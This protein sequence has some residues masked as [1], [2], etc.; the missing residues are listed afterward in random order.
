MLHYQLEY[1]EEQNYLKIYNKNIKK[2]KNHT[3]ALTRPC[4]P[5]VYIQHT[6]SSISTSCVYQ[7]KYHNSKDMY[8]P[9]INRCVWDC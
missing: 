8:I 7:E 5:Q 6:F 4:G 2:I 1:L 3:L 9:P